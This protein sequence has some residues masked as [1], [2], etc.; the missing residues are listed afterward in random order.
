MAKRIGRTIS[1]CVAIAISLL[2]FPSAVL[3]MVAAWIACYSAMQSRSQTAWI[4]IVVCLAV[5]LVKRPDWSPCLV[6]LAIAMAFAAALQWWKPKSMNDVRRR[7][8]W[9]VVVGLWVLWTAAMWESQTTTYCGHPTSFEAARPIVCLCDS[10]TTGL[11][12]DEAYPLYLQQMIAAP[13]VNMGHAGITARDAL[14]HL[15]EVL[16]AHPQVVVI[17]LGGHD[18]L[19]GYGQ[20]AV[21]D[22]LVQIIEASRN[23]GANVI[24]FEIPPG[25]MIDPFSDLERELARTY[26]W[27]SFPTLPSANLCSAARHFRWGRSWAHRS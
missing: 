18:F 7:I 3:W 2:V 12:D 14:N 19:R 15:P 5:L 13:V 22:S 24:L 10:L 21:R 1:S 27:N 20:A 9:C 6:A 23:A 4:P 11:S 26:D 8:S 17:E 25:F 16:A